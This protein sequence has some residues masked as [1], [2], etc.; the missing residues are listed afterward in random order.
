MV[1]LARFCVFLLLAFA[2]GPAFASNLNDRLWSAASNGDL[3]GV[4]SAIEDGADIDYFTGLSDDKMSVLQ[5]AVMNGHADV[6]ALLLK[7]GANI[8][9]VDKWGDT[10][11]N[12]ALLHN[13]KNVIGLLITSGADVRHAG[14]W[15]HTPLHQAA[16][17]GDAETTKLLLDRGADPNTLDDDGDTPLDTASNAAV[18]DY[19]LAHRAHI[20]AIS[21]DGTTRLSNIDRDLLMAV[22]AG[23][24]Q[25]VRAAISRGAH[26]NIRFGSKA[27]TPLIRATYLGR[28]DVA[29]ALVQAGADIEETNAAGQTPLHIAVGQG[30]IKIVESLV[31]RRPNMDAKDSSGKT[32]LDLVG[33]TEIAKVL[34]R[35]GANA[36]DA[37]DLVCGFLGTNDVQLVE[38][39][40]SYGMD[41]NPKAGCSDTTPLLRAI[42]FKNWK[43]A[44]SLLDHGAD[45]N[46][47]GSDHLT[48]LNLAAGIT[49]SAD[50]VARLLERGA[51]PNTVDKDGDAPLME[52][53]RYGS[54]EVVKL[55]LDHG[56]DVTTKG[57][58]GLT[59][60]A[61]AKDAE[62]AD[63]LISHGA[64]VDDLVPLLMGKDTK[65][66]DHQRTLFRAVVT[67]RV[68]AV[69]NVISRQ[70]INTPLPDGSTLLE[71]ATMF[72]RIDVINWLLD[73]GADVNTSNADGV[74]AMHVVIFAVTNAPQQKVHIMQS[75][76]QHGAAIDPVDREG[77]T[78]LHLAAATYNK[79]AVDFLLT[80]GADPLRRTKEG[81]TPIQLAQRSQ[82]GTGLFGLATQADETQKTATIVALRIAAKKQ[83]TLQ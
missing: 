11:L 58:N 1:A 77:R 67:G 36:A 44:I 17:N 83:S 21:V 61:S 56:A 34:L 39:L 62:T 52:A 30:H 9:I 46:A 42:T 82:F 7:R 51:N 27:E 69:A 49:G 70:E 54:I 23:N 33:D 26:V 35:A 3:E 45:P 32:P 76:V 72:G 43:I 15:G 2:A 71:L 57:R 60:L 55:L 16:I 63:M 29:A 68:G 79:D 65:L 18:A 64:N 53:A 24:A 13:K 31:S 41:A 19:L 66:N 59:A 28:T 48:P 22:V 25:A 74:T 20:S 81:L 73:H 4:K 50:V 12:T 6:V 80:N 40:L 8:N 78:P 14:T 47:S 5:V 37:T 10:P 75:L 38:L